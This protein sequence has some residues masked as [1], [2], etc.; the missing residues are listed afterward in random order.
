MDVRPVTTAYRGCARPPVSPLDI[1]TILLSEPQNQ[2]CA[3]KYPL[4]SLFPFTSALEDEA[5][6]A[7]APG[8]ALAIKILKERDRVLA[9]DPGQV[10]KC[11]D[12]N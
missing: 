6:V 11:G 3:R 5:A 10:F 1:D 12:I 4:S 8:D 2:M 7:G 9:R